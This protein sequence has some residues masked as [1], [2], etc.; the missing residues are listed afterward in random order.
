MLKNLKKM[1]KI[2]KEHCSL[3]MIT[4]ETGEIEQTQKLLLVL[5]K[6]NVLKLWKRTRFLQGISAAFVNPV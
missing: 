3:W 2:P 5:E 4:T 6:Y 1:K